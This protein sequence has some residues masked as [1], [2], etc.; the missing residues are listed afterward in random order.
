MKVNDVEILVSD[1]L[2]GDAELLGIFEN[3]L[4]LSNYENSHKRPYQEK[5]EEEKE[6]PVDQ[7]NRSKRI[8]KRVDN[9]SI[10]VENQEEADVFQTISARATILARDLANARGSVGTPCYMEEKMTAVAKGQ[11]GV[12]EIRVLDAQQLQDLGMNLFYQ[13][14]KAAISQPRC[15]MVHYEGNPEAPDDID[16]AFVG[17]GVT[18]DTGGLNLKPGSSMTDMYGD[19]G[20]SCAVV[21]ALQGTIEL[22][23]KKNIIFAC[24]F[25]ENAIGSEA[26]KPGDIIKAMNGLGVEVGNTDA[27]GRLVLGDTMTYVQQEFAPKQMID[28]ATLTGSVVVGLGDDTAGVFSNDDDLISELKEASKQSFEP[29]WHLPIQEHHKE[30]IKGKYGDISNTGSS[31]YGDASHAAAFLQCFVEKDTKWAHL[32]IAGPAMAKAPKPPVC[33]DQTGFGAGLLLNFLRNK[34]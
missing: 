12:K 29:I 2:S 31:R 16:V 4:M 3:S 17:K 25:A 7:D 5:D 27:E 26:Y 6:T 28:L 34:K 10:K 8:N 33:G 23:L 14:G 20:G 21:G 32:D 24:G 19:K 15:V 11:P 9:I 30:E 18:Y 1:T 22:G 13:V